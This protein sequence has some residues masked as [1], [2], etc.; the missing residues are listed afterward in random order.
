MKLVD[1]FSPVSYAAAKS[2]LNK[3]LPS[4]RTVFIK[5]IFFFVY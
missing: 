5:V 4:T 2:A 3:C 1:F